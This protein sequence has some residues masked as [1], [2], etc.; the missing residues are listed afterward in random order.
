MIIMTETKFWLTAKVL[1]NFAENYLTILILT[2]FINLLC[3]VLTLVQKSL[4]IRYV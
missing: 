4:L 2:P 3:K 1:L